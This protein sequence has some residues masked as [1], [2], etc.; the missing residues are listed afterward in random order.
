M[1]KCKTCGSEIIYKKEIKTKEKVSLISSK[2]EQV[3]SVDDDTRIIY[4]CGQC[5]TTNDWIFDL[6]DRTHKDFF[7]YWMD[8]LTEVHKEY[9]RKFKHAVSD[10]DKLALYLEKEIELIDLSNN[11]KM[12][13]DD[14]VLENF[15][16]NIKRAIRNCK[17][18]INKY[19]LLTK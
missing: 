8:K 9:G 7:F 17:Y 5:K 3:I 15:L 18:R 12:Y 11:S 14:C 1:W 16:V 10:I 2:S 4:Y 6:C 13:L 19:N